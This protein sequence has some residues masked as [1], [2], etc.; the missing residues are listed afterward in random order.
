M[1]KPNSKAISNNTRDAQKEPVIKEMLQS[2]QKT[3]KNFAKR[4]RE[5][6]MATEKNMASTKK[7]KETFPGIGSIH[8]HF[9]L[10]LIGILYSQWNEAVLASKRKKKSCSFYSFLAAS[11]PATKR[12]VSMIDKH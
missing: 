6:K 5:K 9:S 1:I 8:S 7:C 3:M 12:K 4:T 10:D 11:S 2:F